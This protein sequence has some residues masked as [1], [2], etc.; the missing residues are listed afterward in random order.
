MLES[1]DDVLA[2]DSRGDMG[3]EEPSGGIAVAISGKSEV[4]LKLGR[5]GVMLEEFPM[6][7]GGISGSRGK[8]A[9]AKPTARGGDRMELKRLLSGAV[10][11]LSVLG[12]VNI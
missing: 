6:G 1:V 5:C 12:L 10:L 11:L 8:L 3:M 7:M 2:S 4:R 9:C